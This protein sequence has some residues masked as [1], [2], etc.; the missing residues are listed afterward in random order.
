MSETYISAA[1]RRL[2]SLARI[3]RSSLMTT[4]R[5]MAAVA[6][7][8]VLTWGAVRTYRLQ[9]RA[10]FHA[11]QSREFLQI[12]QHDEKVYWLRK[13]LV[14]EGRSCFVQTLWLD[15]QSDYEAVPGLRERAEYHARLALDCR[16]AIYRPWMGAPY[17]RPFIPDDRQRSAGWLLSKAERWSQLERARRELASKMSTPGDNALAVEE[18]R[19]AAEFGRNACDYRRRAIERRSLDAP[20]NRPSAGRL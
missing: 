2:P 4:R 16:Q 1:I 10:S 11:Q 14:D 17:E 12:A 18:I 19:R 3:M 13:R 5:L 6:V 8:A 15:T 20:R 7:V 9:D